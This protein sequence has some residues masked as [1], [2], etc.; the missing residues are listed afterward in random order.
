VSKGLW[1][2]P[3]YYPFH[4]IALNDY[5]AL[6]PREVS[7]T[8]AAADFLKSQ[9]AL[10]VEDPGTLLDDEFQWITPPDSYQKSSVGHAMRCLR[11]GLFLDCGL[12]K[13]KVAIDT[14]RYLRWLAETGRQSSFISKSQAPRVLCIVKSSVL[15]NW[16]DEIAKHS[17]PDE[18][19]VSVLDGYNTAK[20]KASVEA[21]AGSDFL[22]ATYEQLSRGDY[23][24]RV[25]E[26][27]HYD[28][29]IADESHKLQSWS[30]GNTQTAVDM[31]RRA[32]RR[33][34]ATGTAT[35]GDPRHVFG[36]LHFLAPHTVG[37][38]FY[39]FCESY[40]K[41]SP[42]N[43]KIVVGYKNLSRLNKKI[44]SV[45]TVVKIDDK[46]ATTRRVIAVPVK[47]TKE[48]GKLYNEIL[49]THEVYNTETNESA[50][51]TEPITRLGK[52]H[53]I[54]G[55]FLS[56]H[57]RDPNICNTCAFLEDCVEANIKPYTLACNIVKKKPTPTL[58]TLKKNPKLNAMMD[59]LDDVMQDP[60]N[61]VIITF[62][63]R[64]DADNIRAAL[65]DKGVE[66]VEVLQG[67][68]AK[69]LHALADKFENDDNVKVFLAQISTLVGI[70][71]VRA[72]YIFFYSLSFDLKDYEQARG[73]NYRRTQK[74]PEIFEYIF[75]V[76]NS[77][78]SIILEA[79]RSKT[80]VKDL[81][82][83]RVECGTCTEHVDRCA[84][85]KILPWR[86]G[87]ILQNTKDKVVMKLTPKQTT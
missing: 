80:E 33:I 74:A 70:N 58:I 69:K 23:A 41:K 13:T 51:F 10:D 29:V 49:S 50:K 3:A 30:S 54:C 64:K 31:S 53:E 42:T 82:M 86:K 43:N 21:A 22:I 11:S 56:L 48:Q 87:C 7:L 81:L 19:K 76:E 24:K 77:V 47:M 9:E 79:L 20:K 57:N 68:T 26:H 84:L 44:H 63:F 60:S 55:S 78:E 85:L 5:R 35:L 39:K 36:Q 40:L 67:T 17:A 14:V 75:Y 71:L 72:K 62:R 52:V 59:K 4:N 37:T 45:G 1:Y 32:Y 15:W 27:F 28:M 66:F 2:H 73:R 61:A 46:I 8:T 83:T 6:F 34:I 12:G 38:S 18:F 65:V 16:P 25:K